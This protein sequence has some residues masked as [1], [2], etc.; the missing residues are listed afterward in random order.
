MSQNKD[1]EL[2][3]D[4]QVKAIELLKSSLNMPDNQHKP[5]SGFNFNINIESRA[6]KARKLVF[7]IIHVEIKNEDQPFVLGTISVSCVFELVNFNDII[8]FETNEKA[9]IPQSLIETLVAISVSTTRGVMFSTFK[10]TFLHG[11][12]LPIVDIKNYQTNS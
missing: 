9:I 5:V 12:I 2:N 1:K 6:D 7:V 10:G 4:I 11:A 3:V 8:K